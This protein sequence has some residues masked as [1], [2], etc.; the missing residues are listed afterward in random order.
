MPVHRHKRQGVPRET[1]HEKRNVEGKGD[2]QY[3]LGVGPH[4]GKRKAET[5]EGIA[6]QKVARKNDAPQRHPNVG[7]GVLPA[8]YVSY[9]ASIDEYRFQGRID[10]RPGMGDGRGLESAN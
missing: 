3:Y 6:V 10:R 7:K 4:S 8:P 1:K 9:N 2:G 5:S